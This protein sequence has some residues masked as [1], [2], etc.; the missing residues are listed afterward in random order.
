[1]YVQSETQILKALAV[2][3]LS[4]AIITAAF[5]TSSSGILDGGAEGAAVSAGAIDAQAEG[6]GTEAAPPAEEAAAA[7]TA[8]TPAKTYVVQ[9]GDSF[10]TISRKFNTTIS[11]I[12]QMNPN[13][14]PSNLTPGT[15]VAVP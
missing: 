10:Y 1:M 14:D 11:E 12:Q 9:D 8:T 6:A 2:I 13:L 5:I 4:A 7:E 15:S 3:A